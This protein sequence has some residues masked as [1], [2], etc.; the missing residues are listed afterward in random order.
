MDID[1]AFAD[2]QVPADWQKEV[3][4]SAA[5]LERT[6]QVVRDA[7]LSEKPQLAVL[8]GDIVDARSAQTLQDFLAAFR[9]LAESL[10]ALSVPWL[11]IPGNHEEGH[12]EDFARTDLVALLDLPG[13]LLQRGSVQNFDQTHLLQLAD[14]A[15]GS[16][17]EPAATVLLQLVDAKWT[18]K[19]CFITQQQ[20]ESARCGIQEASGSCKKSVAAKIAFAHEPFDAFRDQDLPLVTGI[21]SYPPRQKMEDSGYLD[22]LTS[23]G[24]HGLFV[25]HNHHNDFVR[26]R[27]GADDMWIGHGRCG[28]YFP[29]P[30][31]GKADCLCLS[32]EVPD[33]SRL[34][35]TGA[36]CP[37]GSTRMA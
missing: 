17:S 28:S 21:S 1:R 12:G 4:D 15:S 8:T 7:V 31:R 27:G 16:D 9:P 25:G 2:S 14:V 18:Q 13:S 5:C 6:L 33:S 36:L 37:L 35:S 30:P 29:H 20:V 32:L 34:T 23:S 11:Y 10:A 19:T 22:M 3:G 24:F 26:W